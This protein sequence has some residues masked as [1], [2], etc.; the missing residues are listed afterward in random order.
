MKT[1]DI[2]ILGCDDINRRKGNSNSAC[3][4][5]INAET[6]RFLT[7]VPGKTGDVVEDF[8]KL[9]P[10]VETMTR[11]RSTAY[12]SAGNQAGIKQVADRF[13]LFDNLHQAIKKEINLQL[14]LKVVIGDIPSETDRV[15][16]TS[17][18]ENA[19]DNAASKNRGSD[20]K[21]SRK[22]PSNQQ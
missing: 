14:P 20:K 10:S 17:S 5:F 15:D 2:K 11:D 6:R 3:T 16:A 13:H 18:P 7:L 12:A 8:L 21:K 9:H 1:D 19:P 4:V 22:Q